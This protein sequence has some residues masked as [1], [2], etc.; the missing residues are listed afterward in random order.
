MRQRWSVR[1]GIAATV[2]ASGQVYSVV[3]SATILDSAQVTQESRNASVAETL[4]VADSA[5]YGGAFAWQFTDGATLFPVASQSIALATGAPAGATFYAS[6][7]LLPGQS[8]SLVGSTLS[9][10][11]DSTVPVVD[12][13]TPVLETISDRDIVIEV[14]D[15]EQATAQIMRTGEMFGAGQAGANK[16]IQYA[17]TRMQDGDT[18]QIS[19]GCIYIPGN[20]DGASNN[21]DNAML[22]VWKGC[23]IRGVPGRGRWRL[24]PQS[25]PYID[26]ISGLVIMEPAACYSN[27]GDT[28]QANPRKTI[29]VQDFDFNNWGRNGD[30]SGIHIRAD[31]SVSWN[32]FHASVTLRN[33]KIGKL[34]FYQSASAIN[35]AAET[36]LIEDGHL[37][38][39]G[40]GIGSSPGNDHNAYIEGRYL[41]VRGVRAE[42][43]RSAEYPFNP[44]NTMDGHILKLTGPN[45]TVEACALYCGPEGDNSI[46]VQCK[47][48][49][50]LIVRSCLLVSGVH[51]QTATGSIV[52]E[53]ELGDQTPGNYGGFQYGSEGHSVLVEKNVFI[54]HRPY[55]AG[56]D[57]RA[58]VFCRPPGDP[59]E[60][61]A[62]SISSFVV[63]DNIGISPVPDTFWIRNPPPVYSGGA[64]TA[65]NSNLAYDSAESV[66]LQRELRNYLVAAGPIAGNAL[67]TNR[68]TWPHGYMARTDA[69]RGLG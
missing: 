2:P 46:T 1:R 6:P 69:F 54:N 26:G 16:N 51:S 21:G 13:S 29:V 48:G 22:Q 50:N 35:G 41:T 32:S 20:G 14:M 30:D 58:M 33:F 12:G 63:R 64:W 38:D 19:P 49:G 23:T 10:V 18:L 59:W 61:L 43:T 66:F 8:L 27:V 57:R 37:Y 25:T 44:S 31:G 52:Y 55:V 5:S 36:F 42:R 68:F 39:T 9:L 56:L 40:D 62:A 15:T 11:S 53:K 7:D 65:N 4:S 17:I 67:S 24:A 34:P 60:V 3:E 47:G 45:V 28:A